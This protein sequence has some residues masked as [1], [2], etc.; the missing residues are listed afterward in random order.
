MEDT[1]IP[2]ASVHSGAALLSLAMSFRILTIIAFNKELRKTESLQLLA[3]IFLMEFIEMAFAASADLR[4]LFNVEPNYVLDNILGSGTLCCWI[5]ESVQKFVLAFNRLISVTGW[6][7]RSLFESPWFHRTLLTLPW[8]FVFSLFFSCIFEFNSF[9][10]VK[11]MNAWLYTERTVVRLVEEYCTLILSSL[12]L[13]FY[14][15]ICVFLVKKRESGASI[16][17]IRLLL[18][19][20][21]DFFYVVMIVVSFQILPNFFEYSVTTIWIINISWQFQPFAGGIVLLIINKKMRQQFFR[22][23]ST[24]SGV[25][26]VIKKEV[27][28]KT[29]DVPDFPIGIFHCVAASLSF[30]MSL[31]MLPTIVLAKD[32]RKQETFQ[33]F[34]S[35]FSREC[36]KMSF[37][38]SED[39]RLVM[40]YPSPSLVDNV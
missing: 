38:L 36:L 28:R 17:E 6:N 22:L 19:F 3:S 23:P 13:V 24:K 32:L 34:A 25:T 35:I 12:G 26:T 18:A 5:G 16:T 15:V 37:A 7:N 39:D 2:V 40:G 27:N 1:R 29:M 14:I 33:L 21:F 30:T 8:L 10:I 11:D 9:V 4:L 31:R 20:F